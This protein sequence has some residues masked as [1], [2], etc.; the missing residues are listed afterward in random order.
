MKVD[1]V[2]TQLNHRLIIV[3]SQGK[4]ADKLATS[5]GEANLMML[6]KLLEH[7]ESR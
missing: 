2:R 1:E 6:K 3:K 5:E 4:T 7:L